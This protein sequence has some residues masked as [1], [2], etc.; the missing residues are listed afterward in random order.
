MAW[1]WL[2]SAKVTLILHNN[3]LFSSVHFNTLLNTRFSEVLG[4]LEEV[5][6]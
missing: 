1:E 3:G 2:V 6:F 4:L 5:A